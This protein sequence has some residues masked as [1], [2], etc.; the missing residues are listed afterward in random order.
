[1]LS[2]RRA[3]PALAFVLIGVLCCLTAPRWVARLPGAGGWPPSD[4]VVV[5]CD[6]GQG[7]STLIRSGIDHAVIVDTG[8]DPEHV[9]ACLHRAG[10]R[11]LD[12]VVITHFHA[13]HAGGLAGALRGRGRPPIVVSPFQQPADQV[14]DVAA[15]AAAIGR[16]PVAGQVG[17]AG[18][19][20]TGAWLVRWWLLPPNHTGHPVGSSSGGG[21]NGSGSGGSGGGSGSGGS[22]GAGGTEINNS[23]VVVFAEVHGLRVMALGDVE[24]EAQRPLIRTILAHAAAGLAMAPVDVVVVAHHGSARQEPRLYHLLRPRIALI[25]VG[26][27]NDYGHPSPSALTLMRQVG[28]LSLR[29]DLQG[30]LAVSGTADRLSAVT[31]R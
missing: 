19:I 4:W 30:Q 20:G 8:P 15:A 28:A 6:V 3:W 10:V 22:E 31:S 2:L 17:M 7:S 21:G 23:S 11:A 13:D 5:Q 9:D 25:G 14:R 24:P 27:D 18:Q 1:V 29:T 26:A 16:Q 12:L